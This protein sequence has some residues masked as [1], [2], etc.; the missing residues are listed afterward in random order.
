MKK[1]IALLISFLLILPAGVLAAESEGVTFAATDVYRTTGPLSGFPL[2]FEATIKMDNG[3]AERGGVITG[4]YSAASVP[5]VNMEI[6][7]N[8][9]PRLYYIDN[10]GNTG[11]YKFTSVNVATGNWVHLTVV[12]DKTSSQ[13]HCYIDGALAQTIALTK[14]Y[15]D[16]INITSKYGI[17]SDVRSGT[18]QNFKGSIKSVYLYSDMRSSTEIADDMTAEA[19]DKTDMIA[20]YKL[21]LGED[22]SM[23]ETIT[24]ISGNGNDFNLVQT[25]IS[26]EPALAPYAYSIAVVGDTQIVNRDYPQHFGGIYDWILDNAEE[27]NTKLILGLGDITD[28]NKE[29]EWA[30]AD[31]VFRRIS[32]AITHSIIRGNHGT[33]ANF[34]KYLPYSVY[35]SQVSGSMEESIRNAYIKLDIGNVKY[36]ILNID[37]DRSD[38]KIITWANQIC[39]ENPDRNIIVTTHGYMGAD[40]TLLDGED[41]WPNRYGSVSGQ[42]L[43]DKLISQHKNI[44]MVICGHIPSDKIVVSKNTGKNGNEVTQLLID[45]QGVDAAIDG[46][47]GLVAMLYFSED[48]RQVQVRYYSTIKK[49]YYMTENQFSF[50]VETVSGGTSDTAKIKNAEIDFKASCETQGT[51]RLTEGSCTFTA[52]ADVIKDGTLSLSVVTD[53]SASGGKIVA[54]CYDSVGRL[55]NIQVYESADVVSMTFDNFKPG[56]TV[57]VR[58]WADV[59]TLMPIGN[60]I[61]KGA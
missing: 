45:P 22:G 35:G 55:L 8:G 9:A 27:K 31:R 38:S 59:N 57:K 17:G 49:A 6:H 18:A 61:K 30:L 3:F 47:V 37:M 20:G 13:A 4:S 19:P 2:T 58:W 10:D 44:V 51:L 36:L 26:K 32:G 1:I 12:V 5:C 52:S 15:P 21:S 34:D 7:Q 29:R 56:M 40:G 39:E 11:D 33:V 24:D 14:T 46:G 42:D 28:D 60:S 53:G 43:W 16:N 41:E 48:G 50:N 54:G 25:W 23:P